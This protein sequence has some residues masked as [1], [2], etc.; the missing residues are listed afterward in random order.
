MVQGLEV[1][2]VMAELVEPAIQELWQPVV[3]DERWLGQLMEVP[4]Y[5]LGGTCKRFVSSSGRRPNEPST[6]SSHPRS[7]SVLYFNVGLWNVFTVCH[8]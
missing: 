4:D 2:V 8:N 5:V 7:N 6:E 3:E 1:T